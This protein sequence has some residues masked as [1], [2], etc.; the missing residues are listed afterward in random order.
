MGRGFRLSSLIFLFCLRKFYSKG[1][2]C[3]ALPGVFYEICR[4]ST[5][6]LL[7][8][9]SSLA[10]SIR[11][12]N[13]FTSRSIVAQSPSVGQ[14][15]HPRSNLLKYNQNPSP[16]HS[17]IFSL[18]RFL[19]QNTNNA[20]IKGSREKLSCTIVIRPLIDFLISVHLQHR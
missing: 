10:L 4:S 13:S 19:L 1:T 17:R 18:F 12:D 7:S 3:T 20:S 8:F 9:F 16:S 2:F 5:S 14:R 11:Q 15:K 6:F